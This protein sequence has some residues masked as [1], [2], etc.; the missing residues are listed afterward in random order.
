MPRVITA[1]FAF[2]FEFETAPPETL[3]GEVTAASVPSLAKEAL[4]QALAAFPSRRWVSCV[5]VLDRSGVPGVL[6]GESAEDPDPRPSPENQAEMIHPTADHR[7][8]LDPD[9]PPPTDGQDGSHGGHE[10]GVER[11][12]TCD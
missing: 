12:Q 7:P 6:S 1:R 8:F 4:K 9:G 5:L 10:E 3:R 2:S 11:L